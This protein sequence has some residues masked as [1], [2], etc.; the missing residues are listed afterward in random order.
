MQYLL[1]SK[2]KSNSGPV[3]K[4]FFSLKERRNN[5]LMNF[6]YQKLPKDLVYIIE[7]YAKDRTNYD[8]VMKELTDTFYS[9]TRGWSIGW[10]NYGWCFRVL[11][12]VREERARKLRKWYA[13][14]KRFRR[15]H[16]KRPPTI[17]DTWK[18]Y[19]LRFGTKMTFRRK[20]WRQNQ[21]SCSC[22][23]KLKML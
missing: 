3:F 16:G 15:H 12:N 13:D 14:I 4:S 9:I 17:K 8:E 21:C 18:K 22:C 1:I 5:L 6:L 7:D 19:K 2:F 20:K 11:Y 23:A 10:S